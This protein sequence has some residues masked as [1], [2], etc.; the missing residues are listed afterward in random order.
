MK[1]IK[2]KIFFYVLLPVF[3]CGFAYFLIVNIQTKNVFDRH[4]QE[5]A[6]A[7]TNRVAESVKDAILNKDAIK[8]TQIIFDEKKPDFHIHHISVFN[9]RGVVLANTLIGEQKEGEPGPDFETAEIK[10]TYSEAEGAKTLNVDK[11]IFVGL[12]KVGLIRIAYDFTEEE[13]S[14]LYMLYFYAGAGVFVFGLLYFLGTRLAKFIVGPVEELTKTVSVFSKGDFEQRAK[15]PTKDEIGKLAFVFNQMADSIGEYKNSLQG[16][17]GVLER[18]LQELEETKKAV[19]NL[20][21]D[22]KELENSLRDERD[23]FKTIIDLLGEGIIIIDQSSKIVMMNN[24]AEKLLEA[25]PSQYLG[26]NYIET[27]PRYAGDKLLDPAERP[28]AK[29]IKEKIDYSVALSDNN[30]YQSYSGRKF[31]IALIATPLTT[32]DINGA[33]IVFRDITEEKKLYEAKT[34]FISLASHQMRTPLTTIRWYTEILKSGDLGKFNKEQTDF[35]NQ[36]YA[37]TLKVLDT[38]KLLLSISRLQSGRMI[39]TPAATDLKKFA[40]AVVD[41]LKPSV[42]ERKIKVVVSDETPIV[43]IDQTI[44]EQVLSNLVNNAITYTENNGN[45]EVEFK[46]DKSRV[47][48]SVK[49]DGIGIPDAEKEKIFGHFYRAENAKMKRPDGNGL[50]LNLAKDLVK[51][52]G[53]QIWFESPALWPMRKGEE[54]HKG[55][56]FFFTIPLP[57]GTSAAPETATPEKTPAAKSR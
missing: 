13:K 42:G 37:S 5:E 51:I 17:R 18:K 25:P 10:T 19:V 40:Q 47:I 41:E 6:V 11:P 4:T 27:I 3:I 24:M 36:I 48:C 56:V 23:K 53:G 15:I 16:E 12:Y 26:K 54:R 35:I 55:T 38:I 50:G 43:N 28:L 21:E 46:S 32:K 33:I 34:G 14:F 45:V 52:W 8:L 1:S 31:P 30:Y 39:N 2:N 20:L 49:D 57:R 9:D 29:V 7:N 44:L 22:S